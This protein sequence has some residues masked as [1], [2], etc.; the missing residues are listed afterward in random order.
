LFHDG[1][2]AYLGDV[3]KWLKQDPS[4]QAYREAEENAWLVI[5]DALNLDRNGSPDR[6]YK[7]K[8]A[9]KLMVVYEAYRV[10]HPQHAIFNVPGYHRP[11]PSEIKQIGPWRPWGWRKAKQEFLNRAHLLGFTDASTALPRS[12]RRVG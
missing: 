4:M 1:P 12:R 7:V 6:N 2:E 8:T 10:G 3:T 9:D 11:G 5:C